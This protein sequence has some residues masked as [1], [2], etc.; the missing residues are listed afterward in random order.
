MR[1]YFGSSDFHTGIGAPQKRLRPMFQSRAL[2]SQLPKMPSFTCAGIQSMPWLSSTM[3]SRKFGDLHVPG[4]H[5][6]VDQRLIG[7][8]AVRIVVVVGLVADD[9]AGLRL[10][11][12][13]DV[14]VGDEDILALIGRRQLGEVALEVDRI[15]ERQSLFQR[16]GKIV[17]AEGRRHVD[18]AGALAHLDEI[19]G[20]DAEGPFPLAVGE[21]RK[22]RLV[23]A[24]DEIAALQSGDKFVVGEF[25]RVVLARGLGQDQAG[26]ALLEHR[27][28]GVGLDGEA[29][30]GGQRP[31]RRRPREEARFRFAG[32]RISRKP[33]VSAGSW[34]M[35]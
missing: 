19:A 30:V 33:T 2:A 16:D 1:G 26:A 14:L 20:N 6:L 5:R 7:A 29:H 25:G 3:R 31:R 21:E 28:V 22:E 17:L 8:P 15:D 9:D 23:R 32:F 11:I 34:R 4:R 12:A 13:D 35:R 18:D 24:A 27:I 10:E